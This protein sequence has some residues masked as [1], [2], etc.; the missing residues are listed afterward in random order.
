MKFIYLLLICV[1]ILSYSCRNK[2]VKQVNTETN[3]D[4]ATVK[5]NIPEEDKTEQTLSGLTPYSAEELKKLL[6]ESLAGAAASNMNIDSPT[7]A[8][9]ASAEYH[10]SD[11]AD[12]KL[13]ITD[14]AG[15]AGAGIYRMQWVGRADLKSD[16]TKIISLGED[17][18]IQDCTPAKAECTLTWFTKDRFLIQ[19]E[20][21]NFSADQLHDIAQSIRIR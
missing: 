4:S 5:A 15:P 20:S 6:P 2:A 10:P 14:C 9:T 3:A 11:T 16:H 21:R 8:L 18:G 12:L 19:L 7:G 1:G 17:K 13:I